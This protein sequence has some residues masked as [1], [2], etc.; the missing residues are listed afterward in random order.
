M[1]DKKK[2]GSSRASDTWNTIT[3]VMSIYGNTF[4]SGKGQKRKK[5]VKWSTTVGHKDE[6][7]EY[8]N[9]YLR[10]R[11]A[12]DAIPPKTDGLHQID[13]GNAFLSVESYTNRDG[14]DVVNP[15][16]VVT[17]NEI[18]D[19]EPDEE[20][21]KMTSISPKKTS[22]KKKSKDEDDEDE[23]DADDEDDLPF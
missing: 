6:D 12:G 15:I 23:E 7:G 22:K 9:Y 2:K 16:L 11:F 4:T 20:D 3:G 10:V 17:E 14:D 5:F 21:R 13:V 1:A 8:T 18:L 19:D